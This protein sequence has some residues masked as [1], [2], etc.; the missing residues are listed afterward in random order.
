ME[1]NDI[2]DTELE[3]HGPRG[4]KLII[5]NPKVQFLAVFVAGIL[6]G[7]GILTYVL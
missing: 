4:F 6:V 5:K 2:D 7:M 3:I 1:G